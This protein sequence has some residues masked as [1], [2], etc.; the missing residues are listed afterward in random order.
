MPTNTRTAA[1]VCSGVE[2]LVQHEARPDHGDGGI[3]PAEHADDAQVAEGRR[4]CEQEVGRD[5]QE[6]DDQERRER[7]AAQPDRRA[8][9]PA[10]ASSVSTAAVRATVTVQSGSALPP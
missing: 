3:E 2:P 10:T 7:A 8:R 1:P 4:R 5:D 9:E 6:T